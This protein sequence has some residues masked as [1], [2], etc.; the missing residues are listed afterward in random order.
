[1]TELDLARKAID[2]GLKIGADEIEVRISMQDALSV[3][4]EKDSLKHSQKAMDYSK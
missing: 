4:I 1:M 2:H 3:K